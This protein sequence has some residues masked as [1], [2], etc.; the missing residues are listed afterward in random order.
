M[1]SISGP[2]QWVKDPALPQ[3][4]LR[5]RLLLGSDPWPRN[6]TCLR[7]AKKKKKERERERILSRV[8]YAIQ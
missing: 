2:A 5:S 4:R 7:V 6:S 8:P 3:L 1:E